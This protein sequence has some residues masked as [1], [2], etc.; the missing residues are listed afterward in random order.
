L[1][2][3]FFT[4]AS[5]HA[6]WRAAMAKEL[7]ALAQNNTWSLVPATE[8][9]NVVGCKW[10]FKTK[11]TADGSVERHKAC[12]VA[13]GY[14]Q[15]EGLDYTDTFSPV[16]KPTTNRLI[17][18][19]A[20]TNT[21]L[22][23][24]LHEVIYMV[25]P[26]EF[27]DSTQH[28]Y[29]CRLNKALYGFRQSPR[30]WYFKL[31]ETLLALGFATSNSDTS[32]F[33]YHN[34]NDISF[35]LVYVNDI[36]LTG[37]NTSLLECFISLL[38]QRFTIKDLGHLYFFLGIE[39]TTLTNG[40]NLTQ[41]RYIS[42]ILDQANMMGAEPISTPLAIAPPLYKFGS[43]VMPDLSLFRSIVGALQYVT[44]TQPDIAFAVNRVSQ[45]MHNPT[46]QHWAVV[47][48]NLR[49]LKGTIAHGLT[50]RSSNNM[51]LH[52][53][54]DFDWAG[55]PDDRKSTTGYLVFLGCNLISWCS[56]KQPIVARSSTETE[57]KSLAKVWLMNLLKELEISLPPLLWCDNLGATFLAS[58]PAFHARTKHIEL[59]YHFVREKVA[60]GT[61]RVQ[62]ICSQDQLADT[63]TKPLSTSRFTILIYKLTVTCAPFRLRG[64]LETMQYKS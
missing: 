20:V 57:Y 64:I 58:N 28:D 55:C 49:Y 12:L 16:I 40:L 13:K 11:R 47:K 18:S 38:D 46:V 15:E 19:L 4:Q 42:S 54:S 43:E 60:D 50:I 24:D 17:L 53:F 10:V 6:H 44:I 23:G 36:I 8:A 27:V 34:R 59:D 62:F 3:T 21:F 45:F 2:P 14:T 41:T 61:L 29:V 25:Q 22:N 37:N 7:D 26:P 9:T 1:D 33:L 56:K 32:L 52:A 31:S 35:L 51:S 39:L 48:R 63:L 30:A 5:K